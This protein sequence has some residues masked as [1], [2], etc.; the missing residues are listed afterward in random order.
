M[1]IEHRTSS[2]VRL[3]ECL[4]FIDR[5][6]LCSVS[7]DVNKTEIRNFVERSFKAK[8]KRK[9]PSPGRRLWCID[10]GALVYIYYIVCSTVV[11]DMI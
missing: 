10:Y 7:F 5:E 2:F 11:N 1:R 8:A 4:M 3:Q 6:T 9:G